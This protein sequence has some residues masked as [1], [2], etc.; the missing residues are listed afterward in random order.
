VRDQPGSGQARRERP[1]AS[2]QAHETGDHEDEPEEPG[3]RPNQGSA[4]HFEGSEE[5]LAGENTQA[6][7]NRHGINWS[8]QEP[9]VDIHGPT[10]S[11]GE[12]PH[13][14][15]KPQEQASTGGDPEPRRP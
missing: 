9:A 5:P 1:R 4:R 8:S 11:G 15:D 10:A 12:S 6:L 3:Q 2:E 14:G 13:P 7:P